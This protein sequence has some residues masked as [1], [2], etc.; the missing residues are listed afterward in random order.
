MTGGCLNSAQGMN[1]EAREGLTD[2]GYENSY[3]PPDFCEGTRLLGPLPLGTITLSRGCL[4]DSFLVI[5]ASQ[6]KDSA[7]VMPS[8]WS[9][10]GP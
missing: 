1:D 8:I 7:S 2:D 3:S 5:P 10:P 4:P 9:T 6:A